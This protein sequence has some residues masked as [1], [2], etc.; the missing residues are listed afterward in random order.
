MLPTHRHIAQNVN[1]LL[2]VVLIFIILLFLT[3]SHSSLDRHVSHVKTSLSTVG[4][5]YIVILSHCHI[6]DIFISLF[7]LNMFPFW[8]RMSISNKRI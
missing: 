5:A 2:K 4:Y 8:L 6:S 7:P 1:M 3:F